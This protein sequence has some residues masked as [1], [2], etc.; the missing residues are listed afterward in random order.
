L[1]ND[2]YP[3]RFEFAKNKLL[4]SLDKIRDRQVAILGFTSQTF[5]ISPLTDDFSALLMF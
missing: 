5:L 2:V 3:S 1:A 4:H